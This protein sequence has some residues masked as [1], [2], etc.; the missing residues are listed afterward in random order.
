[1]CEERGQINASECQRGDVTVE[2]DNT[3]IGYGEWKETRVDRCENTESQMLVEFLDSFMN[4]SC[5]IV[6]QQRC[7]CSARTFETRIYGPH[8]FKAEQLSGHG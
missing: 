2:C 3:G 1:L 4:T 8:I 6:W 7:H 5:T